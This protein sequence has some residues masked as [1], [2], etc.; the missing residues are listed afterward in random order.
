LFG[1]DF[2]T[3]LLLGQTRQIVL[4]ASSN[5]SHVL[6]FFLSPSLVSQI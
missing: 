5:Y 3:K 2:G 4:L 1:K 6:L